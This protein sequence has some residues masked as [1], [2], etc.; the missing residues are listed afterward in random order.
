MRHL[1][2]RIMIAL[3]TVPLLPAISLSESPVDFNH[4]I[5]PLL[6]N[7]CLTCHGPDEDERATELRVD[8]EEGSRIDLGGYAAISPGDPDASELIARI[9]TD[10]EDLRMPPAGK[11]RPLA[12]KEVELIRRWIEQGANY[13]KHWSYQVPVRPSLPNVKRRDWI[14]NPIDNF[15]LAKLES[16]GLSP[17][18]EADRLA[19]R[20]ASHWT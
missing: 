19:L 1:L 11:G 20:A 12:E 9:T 17:S 16:T 15:V 14:R 4:D 3:L 2:Y 13:D 8:T 5:R 18:P 6:S 7:N 10:D